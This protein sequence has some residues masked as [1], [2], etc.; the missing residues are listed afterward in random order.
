MNVRADESPKE[1]RLSLDAKA[2]V[3][4]GPYSR[5][6]YS[7]IS[8][9]AAD[10]DFHPEAQLV[11]IGI[12]APALGELSVYVA[13]QRATADA[14]I[15]S[16][17]RYWTDNASRFPLVETLVLNLDNGPENH[18]R[19]TQFIARLVEFVDSHRVN[20]RLAYYPPYHSKYNAVERCWA[21]VEN[22]WN[23]GLLNSV[24]AVLGY[25]STMKWNGMRPVV[26]ML[27]AVY[28]RGKKLTSRAMA[29][30]EQRLSRMP[31]LGKYFVDVAWQPKSS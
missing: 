18:S 15:D 31:E 25:L 3:K 5:G 10:H 29:A 4:V 8:V 24:A 19:R 6:G 23:G 22:H 21:A 11:P 30:L 2:Q 26:E 13:D 17:D 9:K 20:V 28:D 14:L 12:L 27:D 16:L 1:L 7:W